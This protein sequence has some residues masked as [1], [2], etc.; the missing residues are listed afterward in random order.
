M[1]DMN[2]YIIHYNEEQRSKGRRLLDDSSPE[3]ELSFKGR[4]QGDQMLGSKNNN[5]VVEFEGLGAEMFSV[6]IFSTSFI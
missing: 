4:L 1:W 6:G 5:I 2:K 3:E